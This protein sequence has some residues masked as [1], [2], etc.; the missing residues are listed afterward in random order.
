MLLVWNKHKLEFQQFFPVLIKISMNLY[1][2]KNMLNFF[3]LTTN[4]SFFLNLKNCYLINSCFFPSSPSPPYTFINLPP[5]NVPLFFFSLH[6][7]EKK[8]EINL[9]R[10]KNLLLPQLKKHKRVKARKWFWL[11]LQ[12]KRRM[13]A[14][15]NF[16]IIFHFLLDDE[17]ELKLNTSFCLSLTLPFHPLVCAYVS[18]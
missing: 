14:T 18:S 9:E 1:Q 11:M 4:K 8:K 15:L 17:S 6:E 10:E 16:T 2:K 3:C 7:K 5:Q 13:N 12:K